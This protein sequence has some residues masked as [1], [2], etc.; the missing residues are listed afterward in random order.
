M[1]YDNE[2]GAGQDTF[3]LVLPCLLDHSTQ[4]GH[5]TDMPVANSGHGSYFSFD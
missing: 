4:V 1:V 3:F 5:D 2:K